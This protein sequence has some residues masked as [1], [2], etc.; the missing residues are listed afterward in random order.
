MVVKRWNWDSLEG[1]WH[2]EHEIHVYKTILRRNPELLGDVVPKIFAVVSEPKEE[3]ALVLEFVG[4]AVESRW[5]REGESEESEEKE[6]LYV[7]DVRLTKRDKEEMNEEVIESV[8]K[9][10]RCGICHD[11]LRYSNIRARRI[12]KD[13]PGRKGWRVW[14]IDFDRTGV[15]DVGS[16][17]SS[18]R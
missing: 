5:E 4:S 11:D 17:T 8:R 10:I 12:P 7:D 1:L 13:E 18:S 3:C 14:L 15:L 16:T 2:T 6:V 9:V